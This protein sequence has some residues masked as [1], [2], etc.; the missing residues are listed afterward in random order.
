ML[1][2]A[3]RTFYDPYNTPKRAR[4]R[5]E[6]LFADLEAFAWGEVER[7]K[8]ADSKKRA[9][10]VKGWVNVSLSEADKRLLTE[11]TLNH[12]A[13]LDECARWVLDGYRLSITW[14]DYSAAIQATFVCAA[15]D[16]PN[17]GYGLSARH[18]DLDMSLNSLLYKASGL[19]GTTW[20]EQAS[21]P[22]RPSWS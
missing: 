17:F 20:A 6:C 11:E 15:E 19:E 13:M 21:Q 22:K 14:D 3:Y 5:S 12:A 18:P 4:Y 16:D 1:R 8:M 7:M 9:F 10:A 2:Q